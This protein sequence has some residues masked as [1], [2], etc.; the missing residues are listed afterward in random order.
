MGSTPATS[1]QSI[2]TVCLNLDLYF[3]YP[4]QI[5]HL[6]ALHEEGHITLDTDSEIEADNY[7]FRKISGTFPGSHRWAILSVSRVLPFITKE[8]Y[9]RLL[10]MYKNALIAESYE[11]NGS[12][13]YEATY[14][15]KE[16]ERAKSLSEAEY[17]QL[18]FINPVTGEK[19]IVRQHIPPVGPFVEIARETWIK[20]KLGYPLSGYDNTILDKYPMPADFEAYELKRADV[21][22][23]IADKP[24]SAAAAS[25][26]P[27]SGTPEQSTLVDPE[28]KEK[29]NFWWYVAAGI[30]LL[31]IMR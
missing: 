29:S 8:Q 11:N 25:V 14:I 17:A 6:I 7:A 20:K 5:R 16:L 18:N 2:K 9:L 26:I 3:S 28:G 12:T 23:P 27:I 13:P 22:S 31:L 21:L 19:E 4:R 24:V 1:Y 10:N 30:T 15:D